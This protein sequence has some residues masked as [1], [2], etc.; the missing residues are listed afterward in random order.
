MTPGSVG[1]LSRPIAVDRVPAGE[2][3]VEALPEERAALARD[4]GLIALASFVGRFRLGGS[5]HRLTVA[6]SIRAEVTQTC[7]VTLE[8][9]DAVVEEAVAVDFSNPDA[10]KG[11]DA[12]D[13]EL[14]D[15]I[16][17]GR[18]DLGS[19]MAEFLALG[20]DPYPRRPGIAFEEPAA[21]GDDSPFAALKGLR[22]DG[23]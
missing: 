12:E 4:L 9:F 2:I 8:P 22:R 17:D 18:I 16:V 19:L 1:P 14:P 6:G 10:F 15:P 13:A 11:T 3:V 7:G 21:P 5:G 20:L 23:P